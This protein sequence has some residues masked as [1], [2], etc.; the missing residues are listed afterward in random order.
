MIREER[1]MKKFLSV[2]LIASTIALP[3]SGQQ[4]SVDEKLDFI[5]TEL[6]ALREAV[7][8]LSN[9][10][11]ISSPTLE[12]ILGAVIGSA[13]DGA[14]TGQVARPT[15]AGSEAATSE[16]TL[17][18]EVVGWTVQDHK[19]DFLFGKHVRLTLEVQNVSETEISIV[20][21]TANFTDRLGN[22]IGRIRLEQ[23]LNLMPGETF[24][25][26]GIYDGE[27]GFGSSGLS[28]LLEVNSNFVN[29]ELDI[30]QVLFS[31]GSIVSFD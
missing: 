30:K 28:R 29:V 22:E 21:G 24:S 4:L 11:A 12:D 8:A 1:L 13:V 25:H 2:A 7:D 14:S 26:S 20:D 15:D 10:P 23:D 6:E 27:R 17:P 16:A 3:A 19:A 18:I 5:I 9:D 31:D